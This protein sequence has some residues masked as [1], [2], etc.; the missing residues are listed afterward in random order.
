MAATQWNVKSWL[1][2]YSSIQKYVLYT[3]EVGKLEKQPYITLPIN[4]VD[5]SY[6][7]FLHKMIWFVCTVKVS[8]NMVKH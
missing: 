7:I 6:N 1:L 2:E 4:W 8:N 3:Y 5:F